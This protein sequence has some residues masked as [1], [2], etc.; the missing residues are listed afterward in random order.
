MLLYLSYNN[1]LMLKTN[2]MFLFFHD[3]L[4]KCKL[5][6]ILFIIISYT[7]MHVFFEKLENVLQTFLFNFG[8]ECYFIGSEI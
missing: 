7:L 8:L 3:I 2:V 6:C 1:Y 4:N 5:K